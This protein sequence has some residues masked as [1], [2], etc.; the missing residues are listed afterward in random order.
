MMHIEHTSDIK[1]EEHII[2]KLKTKHIKIIFDEYE[3]Y[4]RFIDSN[5]LNRISDAETLADYYDF[6][7]MLSLKYGYLDV[8][9]IDKNRLKQF[10]SDD[11]RSVLKNVDFN[12]MASLDTE[13][14][15]KAMTA[16]DETLKQLKNK[17]TDEMKKILDAIPKPMIKAEELKKSIQKSRERLNSILEE[18]KSISEYITALDKEQIAK[19]MDKLNIDLSKKEI[20]EV[21]DYLNDIKLLKQLTPGDIKLA[22]DYVKVSSRVY[23][24]MK[25]INQEHQYTPTDQ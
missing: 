23:N 15:R 19:T 4:H 10:F 13:M 8:S 6:M 3:K 25:E 21:V 7:I 18:N 1:D 14:I 5:E 2:G 24:R 9:R 17:K 11:V 16:D 12:R 20:I 22:I